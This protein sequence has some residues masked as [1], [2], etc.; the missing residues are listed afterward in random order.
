MRAARSLL[1]TAVLAGAAA[2]W[3]APSALAQDDPP[4]LIARLSDTEGA[5]S[6]RPPGL[7]DWSAAQVN[8]PLTGGE[9]LWS[10]AGSRAEIDLGSAVVT[11]SPALTQ[12]W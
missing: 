6:L 11:G 10:D 3:T 5:V 7:P 1:I 8:Q 9:Q 12:A 2:V 4:A